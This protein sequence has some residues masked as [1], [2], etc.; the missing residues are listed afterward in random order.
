MPLDFKSLYDI[1]SSKAGL[2]RTNSKYCFPCDNSIIRIDKHVIGGR[3]L[4]TSLVVKDNLAFGIRES[5]DKFKAKSGLT[6]ESILSREAWAE[7][8]RKCV[9]WL[10]FENGLKMLVEMQEPQVAHIEEMPLQEPLPPHIEEEARRL[11][12]KANT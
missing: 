6:E 8:D 2:L 3:R 5:T 4:G 12:E 11:A 9:F 10:E 1:E 7:T